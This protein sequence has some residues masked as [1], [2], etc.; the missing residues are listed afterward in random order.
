MMMDNDYPCAHSMDTCFFAID[1]EGHVAVFETGE[2]GAVPAEAFSG[3]EAYELRQQFA[4]LPRVEVLHDPRGHSLPDE[5]RRG[6]GHTGLRGSE[7]P[8]LMFLASLDP[9]RDEIA[10]GHALQM[11]AAEGVAVLFRTLPQELSQ[12]LHDS[13]VCLSC[14]WHFQDEDMEDDSPDLAARGLFSYAHITENWIS[15]PY[16]LVRRPAQP[17]HVD[18][19]PPRIRDAVKAMRFDTLRFAETPHIQP[20]EHTE[21]FSWEPAYMDATG[22]HIRPIP[23]K[24]AEYAEAYGQLADIADNVNVEPPKGQRSS[25]DA[26]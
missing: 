4:Q 21:C 14:D 9:V 24:E 13:G 5:A 19:L 15:G 1:R 7:Y 6:R 12:R 25:D 18:Q 2:A 17:I 16:G 3:D 22:Q 26:G 10:T 11:R 20:V 23:S 8:I